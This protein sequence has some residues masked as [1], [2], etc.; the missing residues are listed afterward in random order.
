MVLQVHRTIV[1]FPPLTTYIGTIFIL[2][3]HLSGSGVEHSLM[4][5]DTNFTVFYLFLKIIIHSQELGE[6]ASLMVAEQ[7]TDL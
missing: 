5:S 1:L 4:A 3:M 7:D 6:K 2:L